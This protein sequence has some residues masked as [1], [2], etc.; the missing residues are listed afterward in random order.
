MYN[1]V[2]VSDVF[3]KFSCQKIRNKNQNKQSTNLAKVM[4][5]LITKNNPPLLRDLLLLTSSLSVP[6][7]DLCFHDSEY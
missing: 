7:K 3:L 2:Q 5:N 4:L 6:V 1:K